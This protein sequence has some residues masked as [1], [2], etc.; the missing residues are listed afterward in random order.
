ML[1]LHPSMMCHLQMTIVVFARTVSIPCSSAPNSKPSHVKKLRASE[2]AYAYH[3]N[4]KMD[5][6]SRV[7]MKLGMHVPTHKQ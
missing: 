6:P 1:N 7:L 3:V 4:T 2:V 5:D